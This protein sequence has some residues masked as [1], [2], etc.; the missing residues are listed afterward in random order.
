MDDKTLQALK[1]KMIDFKRFS[2][3]LLSLCGFLSI[4][5]VLP[6][7]T[8]DEKSYFIV[9]SI[10]VGLLICSILFHRSAMVCKRKIYNNEE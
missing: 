9:I 6:T 8:L 5:L 3:I 10:I 2:F 7:V 4:G 1:D